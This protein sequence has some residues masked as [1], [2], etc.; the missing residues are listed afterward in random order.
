[1]ALAAWSAVGLPRTTVV[2]KGGNRAPLSIQSKVVSA[3]AL[4]GLCLAAFR[5]YPMVGAG[6]FAAGIGYPMIQSTRDRAA[7]DRLRGVTPVKPAPITPQQRWFV[8]CV[9]D[10]I[11]LLF[12]VVAFIRDLR[13]PPA[14]EEQHIVHIM[15]LGFLTASAVGAIALFITRAKKNSDKKR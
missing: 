14:T 12:S 13:F 15:G 8:L 6:V 10:G 7:Y 4:T 1:M 11:V 2:W 9:V 3:I 5:I